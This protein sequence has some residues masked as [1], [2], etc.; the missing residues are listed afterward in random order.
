M[1]AEIARAL[2]TPAEWP[3]YVA[4]TVGMMAMVIG[5]LVS[6]KLDK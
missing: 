2:S 3:Q 5:L 4:A 1:A 6:W